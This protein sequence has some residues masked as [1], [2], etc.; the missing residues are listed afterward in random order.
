MKFPFGQR[1]H[2]AAQYLQCLN[3]VNRVCGTLLDKMTVSASNHD[4]QGINDL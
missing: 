4:N 3:W 2:A 1:G